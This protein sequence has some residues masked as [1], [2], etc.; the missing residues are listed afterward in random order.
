MFLLFYNY[1]FFR[2]NMV[3]RNHNIEH[4]KRLFA[5]HAALSSRVPNK[6]RE[7]YDEYGF[8]KMR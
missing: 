5:M 6:Y 4:K 3:R 1:V 7:I 2:H 8:P